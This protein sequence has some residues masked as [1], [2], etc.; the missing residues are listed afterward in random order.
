MRIEMLHRR[1][2][3]LFVPV[4]RGPVGHIAESVLSRLLGAVVGGHWSLVGG[5]VAAHQAYYCTQEELFPLNCLAP[6]ILP[7]GRVCGYC[8]CRQMATAKQE[9][10]AAAMV[11]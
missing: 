8:R 11:R 3:V 1:M 6:T 10:M 5:Q 7:Y 4:A 2:R 9:D